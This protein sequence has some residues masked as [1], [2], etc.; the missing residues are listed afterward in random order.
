MPSPLI[1]AL[2][3]RVGFPVLD[4]GTVDGFLAAG[5][6]E[7][8]LLFFTGDPVQR[9]EAADV[10][11]ILPELLAAFAPR[12]RAAVIARAAEPALMPR[13]RVA[14]LPSLV[15]TRGT[16]PVGVLPRVRDWSDYLARIEVYLAPDAPVLPPAARPDVRVSSTT[17]AVPA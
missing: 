4:A 14:V 7:H 6:P 1:R 16:D 9:P 2:T 12:L 3:D 11:V 8:A 13:F 17:T 5:S 15:V 10:A